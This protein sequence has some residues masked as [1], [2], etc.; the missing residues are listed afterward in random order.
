MQL[1]RT[2]TREIEREEIYRE[3]GREKRGSVGIDLRSI[4]HRP[5]RNGVYT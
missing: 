2:G 1:N 3:R 4:A 5:K